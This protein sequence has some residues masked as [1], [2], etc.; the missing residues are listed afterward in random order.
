MAQRSA[1]EA[2][3]FEVTGSNPVTANFL[4]Q[5]RSYPTIL[6]LQLLVLNSIKP[7]KT[8]KMHQNYFFSNCSRYKSLENYKLHKGQM[9]QNTDYAPSYA[10]PSY[11]PSYG[12]PGYAE[13]T[14]T[15][16]VHHQPQP[17]YTYTQTGTTS[18]GQPIF[19]QNPQHQQGGNVIIIERPEPNH[20]AHGCLTFWTCG[21]WLPIWVIACLG[22][23]CEEPCNCG[24]NRV[25]TI[26]Y[27]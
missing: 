20:C 2:H 14:Y 26:T 9:A 6:T 5:Y 24:G 16:P 13:P 8:I 15:Q 25:T 1:C 11:T 4:Y 17:S 21:I 7:S 23:G 27:A 22:A 18:V 19:V 12:T 10:V 3:N